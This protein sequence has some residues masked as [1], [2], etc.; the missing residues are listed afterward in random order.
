MVPTIVY[1]GNSNGNDGTLFEGKKFFLSHRVPF[2]LRW[3]DAVRA[4]G[5]TVVPNEHDADYLIFDHARKNNPP[6][7]ISWT[8]IEQSLKNGELEDPDYHPA[9]PPE[10]TVRPLRS[11]RPAKNTRTRFT[12]A[13]DRILRQ[14]VEAAGRRGLPTSGN[15][16][17][18]QLEVKHPNHTWQSWRDHWVKKLSHLPQLPDSEDN[19]PDDGPRRVSPARRN[20]AGRKPSKIQRSPR[21]RPESV[22]P[23]E[24]AYSLGEQAKELYRLYSEENIRPHVE[25]EVLDDSGS[26]EEPTE[27]MSLD[28]SQETPNTPNVHPGFELKRNMLIDTT[29]SNEDVF[30]TELSDFAQSENF[31]VDFGPNICGRD[32][33][34][35]RIWQVVRSEFGGFKN[36]EAKN[37]W[38]SVSKNL[39]FQRRNSEAPNLLRDY[40][41]QNLA[42]FEDAKLQHLELQTEVQGE[43]AEEDNNDDDEDS[44]VALLV[45]RMNKRSLGTDDRANKRQRISNGKGKEPEIPSTPDQ[46][47]N[48][49]TL[50]QDEEEDESNLFNDSKRQPMIHKPTPKESRMKDPETQEFSFQETGPFISNGS[51]T[52]PEIDSQQQP[53]EFE[54][55]IDRFV[56]L[57]Y[58]QEI[59]MKALD[60]TSMETGDVGVVMEALSSGKGIPK[61]MQGVWTEEDDAALDAPEDSGDFQRI[62]DKHGSDIIDI[63]RQYKTMQEQIGLG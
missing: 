35:F 37:L 29:L 7:S 5:G 36:V 38:S 6:R 54:E 56:S 58:S 19:L 4:N 53:T 18:Q 33:S 50:V 45:P 8:F 10:G 41:L 16:I 44:N 59:V 17:Y 30:R 20:N 3:V 26:I 55:Y 13:D 11:S 46:F 48:F 62:L 31:E 24:G 47:E 63:R 27:I 28:G 52:E 40:Y 2:R 22:A 43:N 49:Y 61:N 32:I 9:G 1:D 12:A 39:D 34:P 42:Y 21:E 23:S 14:W 60:A 57:G 51:T 15:E 25:S